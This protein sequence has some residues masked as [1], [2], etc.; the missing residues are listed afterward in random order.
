M[1]SKTIRLGSPAKAKNVK[2]MFARIWIVAELLA[3]VDCQ[4][5]TTEQP[6]ETLQKT[7]H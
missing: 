3:E 4:T 6:Y 5:T 7:Q 2:M 1:I